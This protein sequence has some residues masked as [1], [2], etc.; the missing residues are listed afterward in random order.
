MVDYLTIWVEWW[1]SGG[2]DDWSDSGKDLLNAMGGEI[3]GLEGMHQSL[4]LG[5]FP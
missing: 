5:L 3:K 1:M 2:V 4:R